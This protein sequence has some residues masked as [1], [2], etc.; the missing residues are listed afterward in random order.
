MSAQNFYFALNFFQNY[1]FSATNERFFS[2][3]IDSPKFRGRGQLPPFPIDL[4]RSHWSRWQDN[5]TMKHL[6]LI[7]KKL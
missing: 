6:N 3:F 2:Q 4:L 7:R 1:V 5:S